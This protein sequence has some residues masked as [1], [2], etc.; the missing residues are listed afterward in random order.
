M[1]VR[2]MEIK[3]VSIP[4][5]SAINSGSSCCPPEERRR[6][7]GGAIGD[8]GEEGSFTLWLLSP[9]LTIPG[10]VIPIKIGEETIFGFDNDDDEDFE[11]DNI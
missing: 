3:A 6:G 7:E 1:W 8:E 2:M 9:F 4:S 5:C 10:A 11:D